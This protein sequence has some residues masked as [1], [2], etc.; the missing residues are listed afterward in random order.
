MKATKYLFAIPLLCFIACSTPKEEAGVVAN[1][2]KA[3]A[4]L[5]STL[6]A[7]VETGMVA[8]ASA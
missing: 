2:E 4:R 5:D 3:R 1:N 7:I 6:N 8:G